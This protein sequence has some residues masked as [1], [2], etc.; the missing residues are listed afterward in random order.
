MKVAITGADGLLGRHARCLLRSLGHHDQV[1][2]R[3]GDLDS[4][5]ALD[6]ALTG[7]DAVWHFAGVNRAPDAELEGGN[8]ALAASLDAALGRLGSR[9]TVVYASTIQA[10]GDTPYGRGKRQAGEILAQGTARRGARYVEAVLP[11]VF[12]E[13]ARPFY[14]TVVATFCHHLAA[15]TRPT[16][17]LDGAV[18]LLH[19]GAVA[20]Q[21][22]AWQ[23]DPTAGRVC[24]AGTKVSIPELWERLAGMAASYAAGVFPAYRDALD[25]ALFNTYRYPLFPDRLTHRLKVNGDERGDLIEV[26]RESGPGLFFVSSTHPGNVRGRHWHRYLVERFCVVQ[27]EA[28]VRLRPVLDSRVTEVVLSAAGPQALDIPT[29]YVHEVENVGMG[30]LIMAFWADKH[31]DPTASDHYPEAVIQ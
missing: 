8:R 24:P 29:L 27:G 19:A 3:R 15:G 6:Q 12:G 25:R 10:S 1:L 18:E 14:N 17:G 20:E 9:A 22:L 30:E 26:I 16:V 5:G 13:G 31:Y 4:P 23:L 7:V 2:L 11:H 28:V 21:F